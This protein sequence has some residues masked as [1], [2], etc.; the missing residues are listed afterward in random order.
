MKRAWE[1]KGTK[2]LSAPPGS[3]SKS[4]GLAKAPVTGRKPSRCLRPAGPGG[5][6]RLPRSCWFSALEVP[7][8]K[9]SAHPGE[10]RLAYELL[11]WLSSC[12]AEDRCPEGVQTCH[13]DTSSSARACNGWR[14]QQP[15]VRARHC[16]DVSSQ[17]EPGAWALGTCT[18]LS[19]Q[20]ALP[21]TPGAGRDHDP[22]LR[23]GASSLR[24]AK[25][26]RPGS[27]TRQ[28]ADVQLGP[29]TASAFEHQG[30]GT[31][32]FARCKKW[33]LCPQGFYDL[34]GDV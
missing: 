1:R 27:H 14:C 34:R 25:T 16:P 31:V 12:P 18:K 30:P 15:P 24:P 8:R 9:A 6:G 7:S 33:V 17:R 28:S 5:G 3:R 22:S 19:A 23:K 2:V 29:M 20:A 11:G 10:P 13:T 32:G 4:S 26:T 21:D